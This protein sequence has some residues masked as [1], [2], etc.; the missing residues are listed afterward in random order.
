M[1]KNNVNAAVL[2]TGI[3]CLTILEGFALYLGYDGVILATVVAL[4]AAAI[5]VAIPQPKFL[6]K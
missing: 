2:K 1:S 3:I 6:K 4:I 5:G